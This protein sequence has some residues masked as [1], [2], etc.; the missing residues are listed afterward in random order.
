MKGMIGQAQRVLTELDAIE[1]EITLD[2]IEIPS[3]YE[4]VKAAWHVIEPG[5]P[6]VDGF[7]IEAI[8]LHLEMVT[9]R[10]IKRLLVNMP[11]RHAKSSIIS[12]LW[13]VW[14]WLV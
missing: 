10:K 7:H 2:D 4:F 3:L 9:Q 6:F 8:C 11:P 14:S 12:V 13:R 1:G 5:T